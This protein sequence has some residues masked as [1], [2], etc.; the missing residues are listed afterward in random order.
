[1]WSKPD[2]GYLDTNLMEFI[3]FAIISLI[4]LYIFLTQVK[5]A[6]IFG[7]AV[8]NRAKH[9]VSDSIKSKTAGAI[10]S[11]IG[12]LISFKIVAAIMIVALHRVID[13]AEVIQFF[14]N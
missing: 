2:K 13:V 5:A 14:V 1:M 8:I 3:M 10:L 7:K 6:G 11:P 12:I 9:E 4:S